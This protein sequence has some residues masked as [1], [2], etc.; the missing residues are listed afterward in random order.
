MEQNS[1]GPEG[2]GETIGIV[3]REDVAEQ[4][5]W[6]GWQESREEPG[7]GPHQ[8]WEAQWQ[9]FMRGLDFPHAGWGKEP[10]PWEDAKAFLASFEHVAQACQWPREEWAARLLPALSGEAQRAFDSLEARDREDYGKVKAA[11]LRGE[12]NRM[13]MLRQHFRQFRLREVEDPRRIYS[14]LQELCCRWLR[15]ERHSKEEILEL[16]ILE[17]F[18]AILPPKLQS[19]IRAGEPDTCAQAVALVEDFLMSQQEAEAEKWQGPLQEVC[20]DGEVHAV[21]R[22]ICREAEQT[23]KEQISL[24]GREMKG[25]RPSTS[26]LPPDGQETAE[27]G[28]VEPQV[29]VKETDASLPMVKQT[30]IPPGQRTMFWQVLQEDSGNV[31]SLEGLL[32]P[33]PDP[34]KEEDMFVQSPE[35]NERLKDQ[36]SGDWRGRQFKV[37]NSP[38]GGNELEEKARMG[39]EMIPGNMVTKAEIHEERCESKWSQEEDLWER[40][41]MNPVN[42]QKLFGLPPAGQGSENP[43]HP[44]D[45][46]RSWIKMENEAAVE[47]GLEETDGTLG[48]KSRWSFS[49]TPE[50][51]MQR[52]ESEGPPQ[53]IKPVKGE[54]EE[55]EPSEDLISTAGEMY[56]EDAEAKKPLFSKYGR[57]YHYKPQFLTVHADEDLGECPISEENIQQQ[58]SPEPPLSHANEKPYESSE[59]RTVDNMT[60]H[61]SNYHGGKTYECPECGKS[62]SCRKSLK[63]HQ[64]VH[65]AGRPF[66][67]SQC[68]KSY[69]QRETLLK[70]QKIHTGEKLHECSACGKIF[71][72]KAALTRHHRIHTGEKPF[73]CPQCEKSFR[74]RQTLKEHQTLHIGEKSHDCPVCGEN[75]PSRE[76]LRKHQR[77][78][79]GERPYECPQCEKRFKRKI[80]LMRHQRI[81][82]GEKPFQCSQCGKSFRQ[83]EHLRG[84]QRIHTGEKPFKCPECGKNFSQRNKMISHQGTHRGQRLYQ[85]PECGKS[86]SQ[87]ATLTKH[88]SSHVGC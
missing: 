82:T 6:R 21:Q 18:L 52:Y 33:K 77:V 73:K 44:G 27:T 87:K 46:R 5:R 37:E 16:L 86:F 30:L 11:I 61:Q 15:P 29:D 17:Q 81:H 62:L 80:H 13:E 85:C 76:M 55:K 74:H 19:W 65:M 59:C 60:S 12:A 79:A 53:E 26:L 20:L 78:H 69:R 1:A 50:I 68:G 54:N 31:N 35:E 36:D 4:P 7:K 43:R 40:D 49:G 63:S 66:E 67:C 39:P 41:Q 34:G 22:Q 32:V 47:T 51:Y 45:G 2:A 83:R 3:Q 24:L 58:S 72:A 14:Q 88:R 10:S 23:S 57:K 38:C 25:S 9:E 84:H 48:E 75:F 42:A 28:P 70:H 56:A 64:V 8:C 71:T